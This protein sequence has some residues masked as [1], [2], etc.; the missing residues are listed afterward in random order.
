MDL[1]CE[2]REN[3]APV[4]KS[5]G[6]MEESSEQESKKP[7]LDEP[8]CQECD[9]SV[10]KYSCPKCGIRTCSLVCSKGHKETKKVSVL[11]FF[12]HTTHGFSFYVEY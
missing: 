2:Q 4:G 5:G 6:D 10:S 9:K 3:E 7:R 12:Q 11:H 1:I 8:M